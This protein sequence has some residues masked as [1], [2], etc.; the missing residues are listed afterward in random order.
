M[1]RFTI[2]K[3]QEKDY[4]ELVSVWEASVK[5]THDFLREEDIRYFKPLIREQYLYAVTLHC[6]R[7][8]GGVAGFIGTADD[9][10]EMLFVHPSRRA[11]GIG[12]QLTQFDIATLGASKVDVNEQNGQAVGF[13]QKMGFEITGRSEFDGQGMPYPLLHMKLAHDGNN[14]QD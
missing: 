4:D 9:S 7:I 11:D 2:E 8:N 10:I 1:E 14:L 6:I 12:R 3:P 5:A 13:Y